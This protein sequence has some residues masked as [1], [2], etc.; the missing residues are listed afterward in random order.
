MTY[1]YEPIMKELLRVVVRMFYEPQ[2][3]VIT[4][5]L[6][7][8]IL[9]SDLEFCE[10]MKMMGREFNKLILRLKEDHLIKYDIKVEIQEN[11]KQFI[12]TIYFFNY[13]EARDIIKYKMFK[14]TKL[15]EEKMKIT[16]ESFF[17]PSCER[18]FSTLDAQA[19]MEGYVFKCAFC[20][21]ELI[22][23]TGKADE[24]GIGLKELMSS[25][26]RVIL[27]LKKADQYK[28]PTLDYFQVLEMKKEREGQQA[29]A[30]EAKEA[31]EKMAE[32]VTVIP[33]VKD[34]DDGFE[35]EELIL[36]Q[37]E[38]SL[39]KGSDDVYVS[40]GGV[41]KKLLEITEEDEEAMNE[42][43]YT[44]YFELCESRGN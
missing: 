38:N 27:L 19:S 41:K 36:L 16:E 2:H 11:N 44:E 30:I 17:C 40:V 20:R 29:A 12:R 43:E 9:L 14:M 33:E 6:L 10:R 39:V 15:I 42:D 26:E 22:E 7:E 34:I 18:V 23:H 3:I 24:A 8:N 25:L 5:M 37:Q 32:S 4:D 31:A 21:N 35:E 28:I 1:E 13:A